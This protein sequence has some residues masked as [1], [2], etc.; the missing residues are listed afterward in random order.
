MVVLAMT[1]FSFESKEMGLFEKGKFP[2]IEL[3]SH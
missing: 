1:L 2:E 3:R